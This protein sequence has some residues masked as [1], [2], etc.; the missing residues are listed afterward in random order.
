MPD[1]TF[2]K[3]AHIHH[4]RV[5]LP[6]EVVKFQP[7]QVFAYVG[8][9]VGA[10]VQPVG[11]QFGTHFYGEFVKRFSVVF[12]GIFNGN[13]FQN[14]IFFQRFQECFKMMFGHA[15]LR[16]N[17]FAR[18]VNAPE[19][20]QRK[21]V[22]VNVIAEFLRIFQIMVFVKGN[23]FPSEDF[24]HQALFQFLPVYFIV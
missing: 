12:N 4:Y 18:H 16:I 9:I 13:V 17:S 3:I 5:S 23:R 2:V 7:T 8:Y 19:T 14:I 6:D 24:L 10:V 22:A 20:I 11:N 21:P 1:F 15:H